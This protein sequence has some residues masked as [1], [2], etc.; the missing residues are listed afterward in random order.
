MWLIIGA[1]H[2]DLGQRRKG[3]GLETRVRKD[4]DDISVRCLTE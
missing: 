1:E 4:V 2:G 3:K